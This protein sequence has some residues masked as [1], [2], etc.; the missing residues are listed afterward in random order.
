MIKKIILG[1]IAIF[2]IILSFGS[3]GA[4]YTPLFDSESSDQ[5]TILISHTSWEDS[6][7]ATYI[8]EDLLTQSGYSVELV[9]LDPA[10]MF[11]SLATSQSDFSVSA[12]LPNTQGAYYK[13]FEDNLEYV[14]AYATGAQNGLTVP[15]YMDVDSV[16]DLTTE[17]GQVIAGIEP[18]AGIAG[19]TND[20][21]EAYPN[22]SGWEHKESSTGAMLTQLDQA[23]QREEEIIVTGWRP[24]WMFIDYDLKMLEDPEN[25]YGDGEELSVVS[26]LDFAEDHPEI[27]HFLENFKWP[28][29]EIEKVMLD[30]S[31]GASAD[32]ATT[33]WM[34]D[35]P[36]QVEEWLQLLQ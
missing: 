18:G 4:Y 1:I 20:L 8:V 16:S 15:A 33:S 30:I 11:S 27:Q 35:N 31:E 9:Q 24:H 17:A 12:W 34:D 29:E 25:V 23:I 13:Q 21:L 3:E 22:L 7:A 5:E 28:I 2:G 6:L 14:G 36:E 32:Q 10:I 26:R 19:Q